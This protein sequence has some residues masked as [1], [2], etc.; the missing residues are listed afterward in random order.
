MLDLHL[1]DR[2]YGFMG[3]IDQYD[4]AKVVILGV[5]LEAT[6]SFRPGTV[7]T[8]ADPKLPLGWKSSAFTAPS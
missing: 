6:L 7:S 8:A 5:P 4:E 1:L 3:S 2:N